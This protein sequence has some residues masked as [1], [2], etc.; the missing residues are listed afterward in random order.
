MTVSDIFKPTND[1]FRI[2][3]LKIYDKYG[4]DI[5]WNNNPLPEIE[6]KIESDLG[7]ALSGKKAG[8]IVEVNAPGDNYTIEIIEIMD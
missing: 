2:D 3:Y 6:T 7:K 4:N 8:D 1:T 5:N